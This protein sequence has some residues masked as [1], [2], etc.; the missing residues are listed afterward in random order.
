MYLC[1]VADHQFLEVR[2]QQSFIYAAMTE[3]RLVWYSSLSQFLLCPHTHSG[4]KMLIKT[5][6]YNFALAAVLALVVSQAVKLPAVWCDALAQTIPLCVS[7]MVLT[8]GAQ[9]EV[10]IESGVPLCLV[11]YIHT[12]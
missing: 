12:D 6:S 7:P 1:H 2:A 9:I 11:Q 10:K 4:E 3:G 5:S 8:R